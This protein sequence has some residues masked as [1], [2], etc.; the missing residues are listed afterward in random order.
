MKYESATYQ[1]PALISSISG[2]RVFTLFLT[3]VILLF[4]LIFPR[5]IPFARY[6]N[7]DMAVG[8]CNPKRLFNAHVFPLLFPLYSPQ[9]K[10]LDLSRLPLTQTVDS[11]TQTLD[12]LTLAVV[13]TLSSISTC[14]G[15]RKAAYQA[16]IKRWV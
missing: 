13:R 2:L 6:D 3:V 4:P 1:M 15:Q 8:T 16:Q 12:S 10:T 14:I 11:L 5:M 9:E 7:S